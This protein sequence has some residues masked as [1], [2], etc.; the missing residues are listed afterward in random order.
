MHKK[1]RVINFDYYKYDDNFTFV[2]SFF[3]LVPI[4]KSAIIFLS[5]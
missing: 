4:Y 1:D 2:S 5:C 3:L